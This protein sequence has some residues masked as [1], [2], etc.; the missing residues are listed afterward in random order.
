MMWS[1]GNSP[2]LLVGEQIYATTLEINLAVS[3][4]L[5]NSSTSRPNLYYSWTYTQKMLLTYHKNI[6]SIV[7]IAVLFVIARN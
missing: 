7:F 5:G 3:Q 2:S 4:K 6:C 1:K